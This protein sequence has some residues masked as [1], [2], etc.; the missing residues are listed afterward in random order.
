M[1]GCAA[2]ILTGL[3]YNDHKNYLENGLNLLKKIH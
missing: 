3:S 1:I 2:I